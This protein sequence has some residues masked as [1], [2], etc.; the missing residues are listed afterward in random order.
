MIYTGLIQY[1]IDGDAVAP[2][3]RCFPFIS[4]LKAGDVMTTGQY[5]NYQIFSNLQMRPQLK[6]SFQSIHI[7]FR[8][9]SV[10]KIPFI[11]DGVIRLVLMF[12]KTSNIHF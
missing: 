8:D 1:N 3:L 10:E 5:M 4:N 2:L 6:N 9:T 11:S 7:D 12:W